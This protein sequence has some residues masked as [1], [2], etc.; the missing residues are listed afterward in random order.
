MLERNI[1]DIDRTLRFL[2]GLAFMI[3][4]IV[5][6]QLLLFVP[7]FL[8][9]TTSIVGV[10]PLY[11]VLKI[12]SKTQID[13]PYIIPDT[14]EIPEIPEKEEQKPIEDNSNEEP[15]VRRR[16]KKNGKKK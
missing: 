11:S 3:L 13:H 14:V 8:L 2:L 16:V 12:N 4:G 10:C 9:I 1:G 6:G 7:S 5:W 15:L